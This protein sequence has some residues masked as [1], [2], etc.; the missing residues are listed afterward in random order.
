M[1]IMRIKWE[2]FDQLSPPKF[3]FK[4]HVLKIH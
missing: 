2:L 4:M 3:I 1:R